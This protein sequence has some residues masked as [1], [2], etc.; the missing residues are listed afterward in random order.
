MYETAGVVPDQSEIGRHQHDAR[1]R[2]RLRVNQVAAG[3]EH[4]QHRGHLVP[5][6]ASGRQ[7]RAGRSEVLRGER[8]QGADRLV[9]GMERA[10]VLP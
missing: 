9:E 10:Q 4:A 8:T 6:R 7:E 2:P 3:T 1:G 5:I